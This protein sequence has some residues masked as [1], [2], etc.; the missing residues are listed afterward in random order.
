MRPASGDRSLSRVVSLLLLSACVPYD[1]ASPGDVAVLDELAERGV[2]GDLVG[3]ARTADRT[4]RVVVV[5]P[6]QPVEA[7]LAASD[8]PVLWV[9]PLLPEREA[10]VWLELA[11][12][13]LPDP[14][15]APDPIAGS[16]VYEAVEGLLN[17]EV[18]PRE[19]GADALVFVADAVLVGD[20]GAIALPLF[21]IPESAE[22]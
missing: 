14:C 9:W 12:E 2:C 20:E 18:V 4:A 17:V 3:W 11:D 1:S 22:R 13:P 16:R 19:A 15:V 6:D 5:A 7:T 10:L 8:E 21:A